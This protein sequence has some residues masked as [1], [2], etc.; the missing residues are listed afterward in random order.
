[1][2]EFE[3]RKSARSNYPTGG[4]SREWSNPGMPHYTITALRAVS[5]AAVSLINS[6]TAPAPFGVGPWLL[7]SISALY[8][9]HYCTCIP[10]D[11]CKSKLFRIQPKG[12]TTQGFQLWSITGWHIRNNG[13]PSLRYLLRFF[14][15]KNIGLIKDVFPLFSLQPLEL[16]KDCQVV[17]ETTQDKLL[18]WLNI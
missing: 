5:R 13:L 16:L 9:Q 2:C 15:Q 10:R 11:H 1:M 17:W 4:E 7:G 8:L 14:K 18:E 6:T 12:T 3:P